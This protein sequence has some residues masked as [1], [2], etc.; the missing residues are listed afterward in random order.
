MSC[1]ACGRNLITDPQYEAT[2]KEGGS[3]QTHRFHDFCLWAKV[4][5]LDKRCAK[6][7]CKGTITHVDAI[8]VFEFLELHQ[9]TV[10]E[11]W[12]AGSKKKGIGKKIIRAIIKDARLDINIKEFASSRA[13]K[14]ADE[15][16]Q[17]VN[18]PVS[19][20]S[21]E[22]NQMVE[23]RRFTYTNK[24]MAEMI[25]KQFKSFGPK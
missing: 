6:D 9:K 13:G 3:S 23:E 18:E 8:P 20:D 21:S 17:T 4:V 19:L 7:G 11:T 25:A 12:V 1:E 14:D 24:E 10:K 2:C 22:A 16:K 5:G 15:K